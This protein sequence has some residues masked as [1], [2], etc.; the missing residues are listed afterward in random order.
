M[1]PQA[2][3]QHQYYGATMHDLCIDSYYITSV[4]HGSETTPTWYL[5][6]FDEKANK[7]IWVADLRKAH[8]FHTKD[9]AVSFAAAINRPYSIEE[10]ED[11][12]I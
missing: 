6:S 10:V 9:E 4:L 3:Q 5:R 12:I 7:A 2:H 8:E 1:Y 11:F